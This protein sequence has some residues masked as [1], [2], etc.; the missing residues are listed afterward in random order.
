MDS[1]PGQFAAILCVCK[2]RRRAKANDL[3]S[4]GFTLIKVSYRTVKCCVRQVPPSPRPKLVACSANYPQ[5][6]SRYVLA[7]THIL[8]G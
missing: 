8:V 1:S 4:K 6:N 5:V 3:F 7:V 2:E